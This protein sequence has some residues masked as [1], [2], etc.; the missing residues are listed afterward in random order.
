MA[1]EAAIYMGKQ[2]SNLIKLVPYDFEDLK[3]FWGLE[4]EL[5]KLR[6]SLDAIADLVED[7]EQKQ[8][9]MVE[10]RR[11][12]RKLRD[13]AYEADELLSELAYETTRLQIQTKEVDNFY[14]CIA[15]KAG[16]RLTMAHKLK[17]MSESLRSIQR[18]G[19]SNTILRI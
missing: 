7:A 12:L 15:K 14:P 2:I 8:E 11:W 4:E 17:N 3:I 13:A 18:D 1:E 10:A 16:Y 5:N 6:E 19:Q 9:Q